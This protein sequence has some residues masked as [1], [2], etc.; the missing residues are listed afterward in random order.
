MASYEETMKY[1]GATDTVVPTAAVA[2]SVQGLG[3]LPGNIYAAVS[4]ILASTSKG[5]LTQVIATKAPA[6]PNATTIN[7]ELADAGIT[8]GSK[9][10]IAMINGPDD[11]TGVDA[12]K[13][14][15]TEPLNAGAILMSKN[16]AAKFTAEA[17]T[18]AMTVG[19]LGNS[20]VKFVSNHDISVVLQG[21]DNDSVSTADGNDDIVY[22]GGANVKINAGNGDNFVHIG[23]KG[24]DNTVAVGTGSGND[25]FEL[26]K[27]TVSEG[28]SIGAGDGFDRLT[29]EGNR[30]QHV[31][32]VENG[33]FKMHGNAPVDMTDVEVVTFTKTGTL[34]PSD[35]ITVL[36]SNAEDSLVA[37]L[38][39]IVY[40]RDALDGQDGI[41]PTH[42]NYL[43]GIN[44]WM[45]EFE[46]QSDNDGSLS[47]LVS[48]FMNGAE[49]ERDFS[50]KSNA[51][52]VNTFFANLGKVAGSTPDT[53]AGHTAAEFTQMVDNGQMSIQ[54]VAQAMGTSAEAVKI[55]GADGAAYVV[56]AGNFIDDIGA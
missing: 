21:G 20:N 42:D 12:A 27:S 32:S 52:I 53:V 8:S 10:D 47:H 16:T 9:A 23:G 15:L 1:G 41:M 44:F 56:D 54:D 40:G 50:N 46:K 51:D 55:L 26:G 45:Q 7:K 36:A 38:Y 24:A 6:D 37:K 2:A 29:T 4:A 25:L 31:F 22:D 5:G 17:N 19:G 49:F 43:E 39:A 18:T 34:A 14:T 13:Y 11:M 48:A 33:V 28:V 30:A 3:S 35:E